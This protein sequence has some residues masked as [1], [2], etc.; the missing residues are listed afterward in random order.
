MYAHYDTL[1]I[2]ISHRPVPKHTPVCPKSKHYPFEGTVTCIGDGH[3]VLST[4]DNLFIMYAYYVVIYD[5]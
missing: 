1:T 5:Y 3:V 2:T 4:Y